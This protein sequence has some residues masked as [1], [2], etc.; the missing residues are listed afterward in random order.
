MDRLRTV[1]HLAKR[2]ESWAQISLV[3]CASLVTLGNQGVIQL[4]KHR[5]QVWAALGY[6]RQLPKPGRCHRSNRKLPLLGTKPTVGK[7]YS[8]PF[9]F[10]NI[11]GCLALQQR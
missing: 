8:H 1:R 4:P 3:V 6:L 5:C 9:T 11:S 7:F 2:Q 10:L